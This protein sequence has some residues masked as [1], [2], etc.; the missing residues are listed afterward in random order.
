MENNSQ[1]VSG[2]IANVRFCLS[3]FCICLLSLSVLT[4]YCHSLTPARNFNNMGSHANVA[5]PWLHADGAPPLM[6]VVFKA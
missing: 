2:I 6:G 1:S 5:G 3:S 4:F